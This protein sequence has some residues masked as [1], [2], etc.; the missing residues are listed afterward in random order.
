VAMRSA[1]DSRNVAV[2]RDG[3]AM[4]VAQTPT[5]ELPAELRQYVAAARE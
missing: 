2:R 4:L 1:W 5:L 3:G